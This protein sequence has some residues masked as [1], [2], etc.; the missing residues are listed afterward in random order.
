MK[1]A[2]FITCLTD[3]F[4]P[5]VG[6]AC[7][8]VLRHFGCEVE[9][10]L[11]QTCCGQPAVNSGLR[12]E[13]ASLARRMIE[14]FASYDLVVCPSASCVGTMRHHY[15][16]LLTGDLRAREQAESL[17][18]RTFEIS[19][20]LSQRLG[21]DLP[22][23]LASQSPTTYHWPCHARGLYSPEQLQT[24]LSNPATTCKPPGRPDLC[25]GFGGSFAID[26]PGISLAM[27]NDKLSDLSA[28]GA[29]E[30]ICNEGGCALHLSGGAHRRGLP[31]RFKHIVELLAESLGLMEPVE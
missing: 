9:F 11:E 29:A 25:C 3:T 20:F 30:V 12:A 1:V 21:V 4:F 27:M 26:Y 2:L 13:A 6:E 16:D 10:P 5:R 31:L 7:V 14:V 17:L 24:W 15:V 18:G 23:H 22:A 19:T 28:T 8:R